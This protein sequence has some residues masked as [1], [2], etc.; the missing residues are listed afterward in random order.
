MLSGHVGK[1]G[2][3]VQL[4][5]IAGGRGGD[6]QQECSGYQPLLPV[7]R[8]GDGNLISLREI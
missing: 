3:R 6:H 5:Q 4:L 2:V 7:M 8:D 1:T